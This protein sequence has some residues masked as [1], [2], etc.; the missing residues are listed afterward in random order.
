MPT[1][2]LTLP[3]A[4]RIGGVES[5]FGDLVR[6]LPPFGWDIKALGV[7]PDSV[8]RW[9][10]PDY[11]DHVKLVGKPWWAVRDYARAAREAIEQLRPDLVVTYAYDSP[12]VSGPNVPPGPRV[13]EGVYTGLPAEVSRLRR[14]HRYFDGIIAIGEGT[15]EAVEA[16]LRDVSVGERP[17]VRVVRYGLQF[18]PSL[19]PPSSTTVP[20]RLLWFGRIRREVK[21]VFDLIP[22][23]QHLRK[24]GVVFTLTVLGEGL[25]EAEFR[26]AAEQL[27]PDTLRFFP[28]VP[29]NKVYEVLSGHNVFLSTSECEG[30][31]RTLLEAM[32]CHIVP[33][34]TDIPG[35]S[36]EVVEDGVTGFRVPIGDTAAF[37]DRVAR[38]DRDRGLL[39]RLA[40][41]VRPA[42]ESRFSLARM[43]GELSDFFRQILSGA[44]RRRLDHAAEDLTRYLPVRLPWFPA[45][46]RRAVRWAAW[47]TGFLP[48]FAI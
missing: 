25:D 47:R 9:T 39:A 6:C 10:A 44:P 34:V 13:V 3:Y 24:M 26:H 46:I 11:W 20:L 30:G 4:A 8:Q 31:P 21:R 22:I 14:W 43:A 32:S 19:R 7:A 45:P 2:L 48:G 36:R 18:P 15:Q 28:S 29:S 27:P 37:V 33:I 5:W 16:G 23:C 40:G 42:I 12:L 17:P 1:A 38:L 35:Y 41:A